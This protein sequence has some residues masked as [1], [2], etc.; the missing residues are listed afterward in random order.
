M[1][2][3]TTVLEAAG[4]IRKKSDEEFQTEEHDQER[5]QHREKGN[6]KARVRE[7]KE[8][9]ATSLE[10]SRQFTPVGQ[11]APIRAS[12]RIAFL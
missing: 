7:D 9:W 2:H 8:K 5:E 1:Q 11:V 12:P 3:A 10:E 6:Q 4:R